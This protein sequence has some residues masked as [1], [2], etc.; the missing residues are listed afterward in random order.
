[1]PNYFYTDANGQRRGPVNDQQL[2]SLVTQG[3][4][5]AH[6][7]LETDGG[8]KGTAGQIPGLKFNSTMTHPTGVK[9]DIGSFVQKVVDSFESP[10]VTTQ[11]LSRFTF[12]FLAVFVG[13]FGVHDFYAR[14]FGSGVVHLAC[15]GPWIFLLLFLA[16]TALLAGLGIRVEVDWF[17]SVS[18]S[19]QGVERS[20]GWTY[21]FFIVLP[22]ASCVLALAKIVYVTKD[23]NGRELE[24]F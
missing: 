8:H 19:P 11:P 21:V 14:R 22:L 4:I 2:Q 12:I 18:F 16:V 9:K 6:T 23:G 13:I 15:L 24:R 17:N 1:M 10:S 3:I 20:M 7:S 5:T